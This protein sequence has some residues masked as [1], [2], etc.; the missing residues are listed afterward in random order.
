MI[1]LDSCI[2]VYAGLVTWRLLTQEE[3]EGIVTSYTQTLGGIRE[4][5]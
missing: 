2:Q 5:S 1:V 4:F 3:P